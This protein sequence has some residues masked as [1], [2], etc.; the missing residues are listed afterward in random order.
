MLESD[1]NVKLIVR[2]RNPKENHP[3]NYDEFMNSIKPHIGS[4][5]PTGQRVTQNIKQMT[6]SPKLN[7][8]N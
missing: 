8:S 4:K 3:K 2:I 5:T 7:K 1:S 6:K